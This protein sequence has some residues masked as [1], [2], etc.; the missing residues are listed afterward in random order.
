MS[1]KNEILAEAMN[2]PPFER[3]QLIEDL[4]SSFASSERE[5]LDALW[6]AECESRIAA[7][8]QGNLPANPLQSVLEKINSW[9]S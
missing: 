8:D 4:I 9:K 6:G 7:Y 3:A 5:R 1:S 2:L